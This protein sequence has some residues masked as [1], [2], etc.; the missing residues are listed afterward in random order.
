MLKM[1][2]KLSLN[3]LP[4]SR[5]GYAHPLGN[6]DKTGNLTGLYKLKSR[7]SGI[8]IVYELVEEAFETKIIIIGM[9]EEYEVYKNAL[10]RLKK[11]A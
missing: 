8:R 2:K 7:G 10:K 11:D 5:G 3:P 6:N 4:I 9:R 1:I